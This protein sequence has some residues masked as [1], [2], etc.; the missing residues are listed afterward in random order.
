MKIVFNFQI[1][2]IPILVNEKYFWSSDFFF[3][4]SPEW[5]L[6]DLEQL[7]LLAL[8]SILRGV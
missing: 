6:N 2:L 5:R 3:T 1:L 7:L 4:N 8:D